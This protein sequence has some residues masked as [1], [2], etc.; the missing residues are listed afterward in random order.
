MTTVSI[1]PEC[2]DTVGLAGHGV[3]HTT[4]ARRLGSACPVLP[5]DPPMGGDG[6]GVAVLATDGWDPDLHGVFNAE[7]LARG[8]PWLPVY[9]ERGHAVIGPCT[10]P[11]QAAAV[12]HRVHQPGYPNLRTCTGWA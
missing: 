2:A 4:L 11:G 3:L 8:I 5:L 9:V 10:L 12:K 6:C 7:C 1:A